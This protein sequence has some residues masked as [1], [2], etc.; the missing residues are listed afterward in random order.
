MVQKAVNIKAKA[1]LKSST[2]V[3]NLDAHYF[4]GHYLSHNTFSKVQTQ[5]L[6]NKDF[7]RSKESKPKALKLAPLYDN[8]VVKLAK[9]KDKKDKMKRYWK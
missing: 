3:W 6:N 1:D 7:S 8:I 5:G 9:K 4:R 2:M